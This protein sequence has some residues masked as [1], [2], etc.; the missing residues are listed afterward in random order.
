MVKSQGIDVNFFVIARD[1]CER[2]RAFD[3]AT[4]TESSVVSRV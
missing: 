1:L 2:S 4:Y 3:V